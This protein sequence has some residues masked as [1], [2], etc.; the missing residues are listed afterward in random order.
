MNSKISKS[1]AIIVAH[2]DDETLWAGGTILSH[3]SWKW[4]I[5]CLCRGSDLERAS[6]FYKALKVLKSEGNMGDLD[7]GPGQK[8]LEE[9]EVGLIIFEAFRPDNFP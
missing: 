2:P 4:F 5:V 6:M 3:P 7:D 8:P 9:K 1:V